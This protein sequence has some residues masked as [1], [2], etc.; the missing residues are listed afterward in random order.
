MPLGAFALL[1]LL[2]HLQHLGESPHRSLQPAD[3]ILHTKQSQAPQSTASM[4][5]RAYEDQGLLLHSSFIGVDSLVEDAKHGLLKES[6]AESRDRSYFRLEEDCG[7]GCAAW[8]LVRN[9]LPFGVYRPAE[10]LSMGFIADARSLKKNIVSM[11]PT[12]SDTVWRNCFQL[13]DLAMRKSCKNCTDAEQDL[14]GLTAARRAVPTRP[15]QQGCANIKSIESLDR[16]SSFLGPAQDYSAMDQKLAAGME[17]PPFAP[18]QDRGPL[19]SFC[20]HNCDGQDRA[21]SSSGCSVCYGQAPYWCHG[22]AVPSVTSAQDYMDLFSN[23]SDLGISTCKFHA[24]QFDV[25]TDVVK[26]LRNHAQL[27]NITILNA[28]LNSLSRWNEINLN[29]DARDIRRVD[30]EEEFSDRKEEDVYDANAAHEDAI[31][32]VYY[33]DVDSMDTESKKEHKKAAQEMVRA[34]NR[35]H[36]KQIN[37]FRIISEKDDKYWQFG[38]RA[39]LSDYMRLD[40]DF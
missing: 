15:D 32:G 1:A 2:G 22:S 14:R 6:P 28:G 29:F 25:F 24:M 38:S 7:E 4:V 26:L 12:D 20:K 16:Y 9:D 34:Y 5:A 17:A 13:S 27:H 3:S 39:K 8:S 30:A 10:G 11:T 21:G 18:G 35:R 31:I 23:N 19:S 40:P 36:S 33:M 37:M